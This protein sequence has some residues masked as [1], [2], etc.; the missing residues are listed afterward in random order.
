MRRRRFGRFFICDHFCSRL[1]EDRSMAGTHVGALILVISFPLLLTAFY[2]KP[3]E[4]VVL[5]GIA[6][7]VALAAIDAISPIYLLDAAIESSL[8]TAWLWGYEAK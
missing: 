7:S 1:V 6:A 4:R 3:A 2:G 8:L 5:L